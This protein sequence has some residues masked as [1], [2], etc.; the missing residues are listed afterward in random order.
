MKNRLDLAASWCRLPAV[1]KGRNTDRIP[2]R[3]GW[4]STTRLPKGPNGR[5]LCRWCAEEV[6]KGRRSFCSDACVHE[7]KI[8]TS[9]RYAA[10]RVLERDAGVCAACG[11]DCIQA[12]VELKRIRAEERKELM[13]DKLRWFNHQHP[14]DAQLVRFNTRCDD[15]GLSAKR[16]QDLSR[17]LWEMDHI[18]PVIEG[19]ADCGLEN[20][21]TLCTACHAKETAALA[22][23][24]AAAR[25]AKRD[26]DRT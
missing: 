21:R 7:H 8:R 24:R 13:G 20:L 19:G 1:S 4:V 23:R 10:V 25:K 11:L 16:R 14:I 18:Q 3:A 12:L 9:P 26:A 6:P 17:R 2:S 5:A 15:L 22:A